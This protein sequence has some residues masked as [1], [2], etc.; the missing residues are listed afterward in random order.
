MLSYGALSRIVPFDPEDF[1]EVYDN[2]FDENRERIDIAFDQFAR[3]IV[4]A[5]T[6]VAPNRIVLA[7][8]LFR[9]DGI[10]KNLIG[11]CSQYDP[12]YNSNR[13]IHTTL[14]DMENYIGPVA[15]YISSCI[16]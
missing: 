8:S 3:S 2:S 14:S 12:S 13:I 10:R 15:V 16:I 1:D 6:L 9:N 5:C 11:L 4:N 7:G